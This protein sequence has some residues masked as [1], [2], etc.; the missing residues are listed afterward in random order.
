VIPTSNPAFDARIASVFGPAGTDWLAGLPALLSEYERRWDV[1]I[2]PPFPLGYNY[3]APARCRDGTE[4]VLK[5]G[6]P[7]SELFC[8][9]RA[10]FFFDGRGMVRLLR[11]DEDA[12]V[13]L[14]ERIAPGTPLAELSDDAEKTRIAARV[15]RALWRPPPRDHR[16]PD[17]ATW[18]LAFGRIRERFHGGS[19]PLPA[20]LFARA[21]SLFAELARSQAQPVLLHGDLHPWNI[22]R[23]GREPWLGVDPK[24]VVG[25]P[26]YEVGTWMRN[27]VPDA[28]PLSGA[29]GM[30]ASRLEIFADELGLD[31]QRLLAWSLAQAVLSACW[32]V[33]DHETDW[34]SA[35]AI[36]EILE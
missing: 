24:G 35:I 25:E 17:L 21:E 5:A 27:A 12:G 16:F 2:G 15:M 18:G 22:L 9:I 26:A 14:L 3:V 29:R 7:G 34:E 36:A 19:G 11:A 13:F 8:E 10:L 33:E 6:V 23:A 31:R 30:L 4:V 32:T 20:R 28:D 1:T